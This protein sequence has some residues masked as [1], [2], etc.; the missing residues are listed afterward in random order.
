[1][2][3]SRVQISL[4]VGLCALIAWPVTA[5]YVTL[6]AN[7]SAFS[8]WSEWHRMAPLLVQ[9]A[10]LLLVTSAIVMPLGI[11][12]A[13][14]MQNAKQKWQT[15]TRIVL[16]MGLAT[17]MTVATV[18]W[19]QIRWGHWAPFGQGLFPAAVLS[20][21]IAL[22]WVVLIIDAGL[23]T[24]DPVAE[25]AAR[26][27]T[28]ALVCAV[29]V[30]CPSVCGFILLAGLWV[31]AQVANEIVVTDMLQVRTFGEELYTQMVSPGT[32]TAA[33]ATSAVS[34]ALAANLPLSLVMLAAS[35]R[36]G[37]ALR[38]IPVVHLDLRRG[39]GAVARWPGSLALAVAASAVF[40]P[41]VNLVRQSGASTQGF[42]ASSAIRSW[43]E[44]AVVNRQLLVE[45]LVAAM[46]TGMA[47]SALAMVVCWQ[48]RQ[49]RFLRRFVLVLAALT[50]AV[51]GPVVG[52]GLREAIDLIVGVE[53]RWGGSMGR[54]V[55]YDG[56][57]LLPAAWAWLIRGW[58]IAIAVW[59]P[60]IARLPVEFGDATRLESGSWLARMR[61]DLWPTLGRTFA[62]AAGLVAVLSLGEVSAS[63]LVATPGGQSM[64]HDV[65]ARMHY[66]ITPELAAMC[67]ALL[68]FTVLLMMSISWLLA[69]PAGH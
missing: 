69:R 62:T 54:A 50:L 64:A 17:P 60:D 24:L 29:R 37:W 53:E 9:T 55:L 12:I 16:M 6:A 4:V 67:L 7:P 48:A 41:I 49:S 30:T 3:N 57:S 8:V 2:G 20:A 42:V 52:L 26:L 31:A 13:L 66:G 22:P 36:I 35:L 46:F 68:P 28:S 10:G 56:P 38:K 15:V 43:W 51:P 18:A 47:C 19:H 40:V 11:A 45:S 44:A 39:N 34:R 14:A 25:D 5:A 63:R 59:W 65:F 27:E 23:A 33:A 21:T 1:M 61:H 32:E 58:P